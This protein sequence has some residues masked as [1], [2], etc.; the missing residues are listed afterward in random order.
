VYEHC[1]ECFSLALDLNVDPPDDDTC[2]ICFALRRAERRVFKGTIDLVRTAVQEEC[3][4]W[5]PYDLDQDHVLSAID[6]I[7]HE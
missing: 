1:P 7:I 4:K 5:S 3:E 6:R 2:A